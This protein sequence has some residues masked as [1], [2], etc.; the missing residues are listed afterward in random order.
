MTPL[1]DTNVLAFPAK[2]QSLVVKKSRLKS[3]TKADWEEANEI[4]KRA[5]CLSKLSLE[6][7][8]EG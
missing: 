7:I 5:R 4:T 1:R 8:Y 2:K 3:M 6:D